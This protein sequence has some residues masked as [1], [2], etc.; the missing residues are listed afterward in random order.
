VL[1]RDF[2][3]PKK[4]VTAQRANALEK[5]VGTGTREAKPSAINILGEF[6]L[7]GELWILLEY[8]KKKGIM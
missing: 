3:E 7:A 1:R 2:K 8:Y 6:N 5:L 4:T